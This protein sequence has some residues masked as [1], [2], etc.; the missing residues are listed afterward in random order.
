M[1]HVNRLA[2]ENS[3]Y[4][5]QHAHNP[6][7]WYPW[8]AEALDRARAEDKPIFLSIGYSTCHWCHVMER[9]SFENEEIAR[10][11]NERFVCIKVDREER[12]DLDE[13]Y[14]TAVQAMTGQGGW[15]M[16]TILTPSLEPFF[17]GTYFPPDDRFGRPGLPAVLRQIDHVW[18][19][20]RAEVQTV[21]SEMRNA[22]ARH[23]RL[24]VGDA[25]AELPGLPLLH[26]AFE[27]SEALYDERHGGFGGAPKFPTPHR[28]RLLLRYATRTG[29]AKALD[30]VTRSLDEMAMGG[31]HDHVGGGFHRYATDAAWL[32]PHF[33]KMLY[34]QAGLALLYLEAWLATH[35]APYERVARGIL[36]YVLRDLSHEAG[37]FFSAEDADSEGIEG[38]F[39]VWSEDEL[40]GLFDAKEAEA[41]IATY[42]VTPVGNWEHVNI[43]HTRSLDPLSDERL[44]RLREDLLSHRSRRIRPHRDEKI[45][46]AWNAFMIEAFARAGFALDEPRY[47]DAARRCAAFVE[48]NLWVSGRLRRHYTNGA[49]EIGAYLDDYAFLGRSLV[50]LYE[51]T[52]DTHYLAK[53]IEIARDVEALFSSS[54][55]AFQ[56]QG[57]DAEALLA[58]VI[59]SYDGAIPSGNAVAAGL[60]LRLGHLTGDR[61]MEE[62]GERVLR[63]FADP[64]R[65]SPSNFAEMLCAVDFATGP[66]SELVF[67]GDERDPTFAA[68]RGVTRGRFLPNTVF[69]H[70]PATNPEGARGLV[71][72]LGAQPPEANGAIAYLCRNQ[73]CQLPARD[74][75]TLADQLE[76]GS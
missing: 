30:M 48:K 42:G 35:R 41:L 69:A 22:L 58:P 45:V 51:V 14:M 67:A 36:D 12:P 33:E 13:L 2:R 60:F 40:R 75:R 64:A 27:E 10:F 37:G 53:A 49:S 46:T 29:R 68:L 50:A 5:R 59:E 66:I 55:N 16:T 31:I 57:S 4:L 24:S 43:L 19:S 76:A 26:Q 28:L 62:R 72:Y 18:R 9:E 6:V 63:V 8:S 65:R 71:S 38:K 25:R 17:A 34:D 3:P 56:L 15:P 70:H 39:Y 54:S 20:Q 47:V 1:A 21:A 73:S 23:A 52:F 74:A 11:L 7:D 32:V 61:A 44:A